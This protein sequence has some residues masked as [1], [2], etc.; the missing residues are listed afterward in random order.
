M[1]AGSSNQVKEQ[2]ASMRET[3]YTCMDVGLRLLSPFMPFLTEELW[4]RLRRRASPEYQWESIC[5]ADYPQ[6][7]NTLSISIYPSTYLSIPPR[8]V[9]SYLL[10]ESIPFP[11]M[12]YL[13]PL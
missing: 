9:V 1:N 12:L 2:Q 11:P 4:Q 13:F 5:I 7:V 8:S 10:I 3:L 6:P